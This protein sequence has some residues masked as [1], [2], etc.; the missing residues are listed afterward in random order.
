MENRTTPKD[1]FLHLGATVVLYSAAIALINLVWSAIDYALPDKLAGSFY[2]PSMAWPISMLIVLVPLL[3][4]LE[5]LIARDIAKVPE[6][7]EVWIRRWRIYLTLF[8][9]GATIVGDLI[10]LVNTYLSGEITGR[11]VWKVLAIL[12]ICGVIFAYYL[13]A[14]AAETIPVKVWKRILAWAGI[15]VAVATVAG[16]FL[17]TGSPWTQRA[18]RFDSQRESDLQSIQWQVISAWQQKGKLPAALSDLNDSI[19][20]YSAPTDP[21]TSLAYG[22]TVKGTTSFELCADFDLATPDTANRGAYQGGTGGGIVYPASNASYPGYYGTGSD[23]WAHAAGHVCFE[24]TIDPV[25]YPVYQNQTTNVATPP[26][27]VPA[28]KGI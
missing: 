12:V 28:P 23:S 19:S 9:S 15:V 18:L 6:K 27:A 11:F 14:R 10:A 26:V 1:F 4:I 24:R 22:Y 7:K 16:G 20:G 8:L 17:I 3:Y 2:A 13:L 5:W 25:K 21:N